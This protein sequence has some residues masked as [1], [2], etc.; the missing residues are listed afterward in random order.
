MEYGIFRRGS[1]TICEF[2]FPSAASG[3]YGR[4]LL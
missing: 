3:N 1:Q 2:A 4:M